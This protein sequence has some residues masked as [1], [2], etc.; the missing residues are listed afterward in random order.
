MLESW[1][2]QQC[3]PMGY[4]SYDWRKKGEMKSRIEHAIHMVSNWKSVPAIGNPKATAP[5]EQV[6]AANDQPQWDPNPPFVP[7]PLSRPPTVPDEKNRTGKG[8]PHAQIQHNTTSSAWPSRLPS[9]QMIHRRSKSHGPTPDP[10][11]WDIVTPP[12][13]KSRQIYSTTRPSTPPLLKPHPYPQP[14]VEQFDCDNAALLHNDRGPVIPSGIFAK[15]NDVPDASSRKKRDKKRA[16][17]LRSD[18]LSKWF[19][20]GYNSAD[21]EYESDDPDQSQS[22]GR[23]Q[24]L[25]PLDLNRHITP[26]DRQQQIQRQSTPHPSAWNIYAQPTTNQAQS[27]AP[28]ADRYPSP[29]PPHKTA[30]IPDATMHRHRHRPPPLDLSDSELSNKFGLLNF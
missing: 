2:L 11:D 26:Q 29:L 30:Q 14:H 22:R 16:T 7:P 10:D 9:P 15:R 3:W 8:W 19:K 5:L 1:L 28:H 17:H 24:H 6:V 4:G 25:H 23:S 12:R 13:P 18:R 20:R 27:V 21:G